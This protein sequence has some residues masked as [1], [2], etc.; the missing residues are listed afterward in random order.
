M[1]ESHA[2]AYKALRARVREIVEA[3]DPSALSVPVAATPR[4]RAHDVLAHLVGVPDDVV[5]GRMENLASDEWTQAQVDAR[6]AVTPRELLEEWDEKGAQFEMLLAASPAA[7]A[8]Q[9]IFDAGTHEHDLRNALGVHGE[10]D[11]DAIRSGWDWIVD[12]RT[13][14]KARAICFVTED[15]EETSGVGERVARVEAPRFELFRAVAGR[16]TAAEIA[17]YGWDREPDAQLL[18]AA[19]FFSLPEHSLGE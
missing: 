4:W 16:R 15:G 18:L 11:T 19:D 3:A 10:R 8:G 14:G 6:A 17:A 5:N 2:V 1:S 7:I 12:A 13:R 9:A